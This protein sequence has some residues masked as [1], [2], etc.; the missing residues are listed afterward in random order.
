M[1]TAAACIGYKRDLLT[2][3][4]T[5]STEQLNISRKS[6]YCH[7]YCAVLCLPAKTANQAPASLNLLRAG[8]AS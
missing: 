1:E 6:A 8:A 3:T 4:S 7:S 2:S 5:A